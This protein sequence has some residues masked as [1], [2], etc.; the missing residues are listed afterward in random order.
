[1]KNTKTEAFNFL[2]EKGINEY[3]LESAAEYMCIWADKFTPK[4]VSDEEIED[5]AKKRN[6][7]NPQRK[8]LDAVILNVRYQLIDAMKWMRDKM[9]GE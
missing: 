6:P 1:M 3:W 2:K 7:L 4:E 8:D 5:E 9:K